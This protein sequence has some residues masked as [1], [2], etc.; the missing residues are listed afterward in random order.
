[1]DEARRSGNK[2]EA[3]HRSVRLELQA[4]YLAGVWAY[5]GQKKY[6]FLDPG[7]LESALNAANQIGDDRLQKKARGYVVPDSFTHGTSAQRQRWFTKGFETGDVGKA[8]ELFDR[9]YGAL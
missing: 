1:V 5:H 6:N 7:D 8:R 2:V 4:D 9:D 3:N